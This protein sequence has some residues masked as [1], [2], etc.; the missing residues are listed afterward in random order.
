MSGACVIVEDS[1]SI[2]GY[3]EINDGGS[4]DSESKLEV[5]FNSSREWL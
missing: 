3:Q 5:S 2:A 1:R 4:R